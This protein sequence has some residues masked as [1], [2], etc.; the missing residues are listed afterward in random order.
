MADVPVAFPNDE[1]SAEVIASRLR[2]TGI[3]AR[4]DRGLHGSWQVPAQGQITVFVDA[5]D[6]ARAHEMLGTKLREDVAP[7]PFLRLAVAFLLVALVVSVIA[8]VAT[9][10]GR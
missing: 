10:A 6:A 8:V 2:E 5:G 7:G 4:V 3:A 9:V 1:A